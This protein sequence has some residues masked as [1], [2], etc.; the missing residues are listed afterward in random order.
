MI[1][2]TLTSIAFAAGCAIA[3]AAPAQAQVIATQAQL[4]TMEPRLNAGHSVEWM[5][6]GDRMQDGRYEHRLRTDPAFRQSRMQKECG[7]IT[8]MVLRV[9]CEDS[10]SA[11]QDEPSLGWQERTGGSTGTMNST[12]ALPDTPNTVDPGAGR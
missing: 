9:R 4:R 1:K 7:P 6:S 8:D 3:L 12:G 11:W 2:K 5:A 10:F